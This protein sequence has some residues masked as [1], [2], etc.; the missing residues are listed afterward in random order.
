MDFTA[1]VAFLLLITAPAATP[2]D[3]PRFLGPNGSGVSAGSEVPTEFG[4]GKNLVWKTAVPFAR[5]SPVVSGNRVYLTA[6]EDKNLVV[7]QLDRDTGKILWRRDLARPRSTP[8]YKLNDAA[9]PTPVTD[10]K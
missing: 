2:Q 6:S 4:P 10:G 9:S 5:S 1:R 3:W 7:L 8:I